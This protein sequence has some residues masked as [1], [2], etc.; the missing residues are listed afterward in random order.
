ME[1]KGKRNEKKQYEFLEINMSNF[2][3][4]HEKRHPDPS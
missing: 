2:G 3:D 4:Y 1:K